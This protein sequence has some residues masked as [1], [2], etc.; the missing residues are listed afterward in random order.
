MPFRSD[1][2]TSSMTTTKCCATGLSSMTPSTLG[3]PACRGKLTNGPLR[4]IEAQHDST[5]H[6][7]RIPMT[8][9]IERRDFIR[10]VGLIAGAAVAATLIE[11]PTLAQASSISGFTP[12]TY[13][14]KPLPFDPK[15][16]KGLSEKI[17]VSHFE[18]NYSGAV[19]R[20]N[21]IGAQ[22]AELDFAKA[23]VFVINGL[24]REELVAMNSMILHEL[25][26]DGLGAQ[27]EADRALREALARDFGSVDRWRTEF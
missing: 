3:A 8:D 15:A 25:Y 11:S 21:A 6:R 17:L 14:I 23:P 20:L 4:A 16:I 22:L 27:G 19:K 2:P 13:K 9:E 7:E 12:M 24:K 5:H 1:F 18:N 10:G 26:F